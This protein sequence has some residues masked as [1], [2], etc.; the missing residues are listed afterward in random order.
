MQPIGS[1]LNTP[2]I[3]ASSSHY[4]QQ[5]LKR[6]GLTF[7]V[8]PPEIDESPRPDEAPEKLV[9]RLARTK[10]ISVA[11][12]H[13]DAVVIGADQVALLGDRLLGK[14]GS[15]D[16]AVQQLMDSSGRWVKCLTGLC[17]VHP[18]R[19]VQLGIA[20]FSV[21]LRHLT[22]YQIE[23]YVR[24]EKPYDCAGSF[25][26]ESLGIALFQRMKGDDPTAL[27]GLPLITLVEMFN[28]VGIDVLATDRAGT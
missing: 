25:K 20:P 15:H 23:S 22:R 28:G 10:A 7:T 14:P 13:A 11:Q 5:L 12:H 3:L 9:G 4:R 16:A 21:L 24:L 18:S 19:G 26:A 1:K 6:L 2:L 17:L 27:I 8:V